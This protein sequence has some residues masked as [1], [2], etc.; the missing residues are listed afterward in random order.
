VAVIV[1]VLVI[2]AVVFGVRYWTWS[3]HHIGTDD[4]SIA[5][6]TVQVAPQ[7][8]GAVKQVFVEDNQEVK[9]GTL[10][11]ELDDATYRADVEQAKANLDAAIAQA[12]GAGVSVSLAEQTGGAQQEQ[13]QGGLAQA[14][15]GV[16]GARQDAARAVAAVSTA[17]AQARSAG[18]TARAA[19][20]GIAAA[21]ANRAHAVS[22]LNAARAQVDTA[23]AAVSSAEAG[24]VSAQASAD[25]AAKD[26]RRYQSLLAQGAVGQQMVDQANAGATAAQAALDAARQQVEGAKAVLVAR[27]SDVAAARDQIGAADA[28]I[29]QVRQQAAALRDQTVAAKAGITAAQAQ[30]AAAVQ[31]IQTAEARQQQAHGAVSAADTSPRQVA[32]SRTAHEQARARIEQ[33]RAALQQARI[34]LGYTRIVAPVSGRVSKKSVEIGG[35]VQPGTPLMALVQGDDLWVVANFKETQMA[36]ITPGLRADVEVDALPGQTFRGHVES[37]SAATGSTFALL[38]ADNAT[39]NFTKVVQRIPVKIALEPGQPKMERLRAGMS[40]DATVEI[41]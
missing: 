36:G 29:E 3:S 11:V 39:G 1:A 40:V 2:A 16:A 38:P 6:D 15:S 5:A 17:A 25:R 9:A 28:A 4:A 31:A 18:S 27:Q 35:L 22:A 34:R 10:L 21:V 41:R 24:V 20:S 14:E 19:E 8:S 23:R 37:V 32:V 12:K 26:A 33:A 7:V 13:A 30:S